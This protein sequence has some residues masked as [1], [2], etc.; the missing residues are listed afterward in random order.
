[1]FWDLYLGKSGSINNAKFISQGC[2]KKL[3]QKNHQDGRG[4]PNGSVGT[5]Y[6]LVFCQLPS[7]EI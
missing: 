1:M 3:N 4:E 2:P 5:I 7:S 6:K